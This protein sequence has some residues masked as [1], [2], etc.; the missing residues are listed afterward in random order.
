MVLYIK[1]FLLIISIIIL[2]AG[3]TFP[4]FYFSKL[5]GLILLI[6]SVRLI[7]KGELKQET[8]QL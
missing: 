1:A 8:T 7:I 3:A 2:G 4:T 6:I 5:T